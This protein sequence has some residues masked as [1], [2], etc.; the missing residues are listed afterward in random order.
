MFPPRL[1]SFVAA[2]AMLLLLAGQQARA[3]SSLTLTLSGYTN[4]I[5][6]YNLTL[7][8]Q[9]YSS[10]TG[11]KNSQST[12]T[13]PYFFTTSTGAQI[14][15]F[16]IDVTKSA[17]SGTYSTSPLSA[18]T[19]STSLTN[20]ITALYGFYY[21]YNSTTGKNNANW[22][23]LSGANASNAKDFTAFQLALWELVY[24]GSSDISNPKANNYFTSGNFTS[25]DPNAAE[26]QTMLSNVLQNTAAGDLAF[27]N[28]LG[29][30]YSIAA[31]LN[32][33]AQTQLYLQPNPPPAIVQTPAPPALLLAGFGLAMM[34]GRARL[35][36]RTPPAAA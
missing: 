25:S 5:V 18:Y 11:G 33:S 36:R 6:D 9:T 31:L 24:D 20:A 7:N 30:S 10:P 8:G 26:A 3:D 13:G 16:C 34:I 23:T 32:T 28:G 17:S 27:S 2:G 15:T 1:H 12:I 4:N 21:D 14:S 35:S 29:Q 19:G 22:S